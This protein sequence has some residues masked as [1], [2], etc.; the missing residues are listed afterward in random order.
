MTV[1]GCIGAEED[2]GRRVYSETAAKRARRSTVPHREFLAKRGD[3][4]ISVD[5]LSTV[6]LDQVAVL[7]QD[8]S[9]TRDGPFCG[10]ASVTY[11]AASRNGR[12]VIASPDDRNPYHGEI[13]LPDSAA[14]DRDEQIRHAQELADA[15]RWCEEPS[16]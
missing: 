16:A 11:G 4:S 14:V 2:L 7:A 8:A 9:A 6:A 10:W 15:S 3:T 13:V 1:P 5:R 12:R